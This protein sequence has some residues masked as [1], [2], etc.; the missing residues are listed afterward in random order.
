MLSDIY[1][2]TL[3][4]GPR[5]E[6]LRILAEV[7]DVEDGLGVRQVVL[8]QVVV[9]SGAYSKLTAPKSQGAKQTT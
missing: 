7:A 2:N 4:L 8:L 6:G 3:T 5:V 9:D 1:P